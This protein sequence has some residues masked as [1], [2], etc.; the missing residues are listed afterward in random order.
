MPDDE[1]TALAAKSALTKPEV[2]QKQIDRMLND[3]R[4]SEFHNGF[5]GQWLGLAK[6]DDLMIEDERWVVRTGLRN[7]MRAEPAHFFAELLRG[8]HSLL[9]FIDSDFA[10]INE[11]LAQHYR[12]PGVFGNEFR[13]VSLP[14]DSVRGG[15][16]TQA[17]SLAIT[18]DGMITSPIYRG[19][20]VMEKILDLPPPPPPPNVPP[21]DDA[22]WESHLARSAEAAP[23]GSELRRLSQEN[24]PDWLAVRELQHPR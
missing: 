7:S 5:M 13:R 12:I 14:K 23:R 20:W 8:N 17:S 3:E 9:N 22:G 19:K 6:L 24:R 18:T 11:R 10:M 4:A 21:L 15:L 2:L 16:L 1:L